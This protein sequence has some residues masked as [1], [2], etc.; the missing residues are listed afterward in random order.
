MEELEEM[1]KNLNVTVIDKDSLDELLKKAYEKPFNYYEYVFKLTE[2]EKAKLR[3]TPIDENKN[4][5]DFLQKSIALYILDEKNDELKKEAIKQ[6]KIEVYGEILEYLNQMSVNFI[7]KKEGQSYKELK[8]RYYLFMNDAIWH[9]GLNIRE[10]LDKT[11]GILQ[12]NE[13]M[14]LYS[15][16]HEPPYRNHYSSIFTSGEFIKNHRQGSM[17]TKQYERIE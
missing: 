14:I 6:I 7:Y 17:K 8:T 5:F 4:N 10:K 9:I 1:F 12:E 3:K 11:K 13:K 16:H 2:F 15:Y